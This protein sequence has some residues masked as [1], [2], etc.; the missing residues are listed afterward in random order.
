MKQSRNKAKINHLRRSFIGLFLR[1]MIRPINQG[2][3]FCLP[4]PD[5]ATE[6]P[7]TTHTA[8]DKTF[9]SQFT[10]RWPPN[11]LSGLGDASLDDEPAV[12]DAG[13]YNSYSRETI[14]ESVTA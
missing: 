5:L 13:I 12:L 6:V 10:F 9:L 11:L 8:A 3:L 2:L 1:R 14:S 7:M 4:K